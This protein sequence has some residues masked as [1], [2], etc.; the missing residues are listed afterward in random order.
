MG[1][2]LVLAALNRVVAPTSKLGFA[3]WWATTALDRFT[4]IPSR[5]LDHRRFWDA[6]HQV[7]ME[8]LG[9][10]EER[11]ALAMIEEFGLDISALALDRGCQMVCVRGG[12]LA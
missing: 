11:I 10:I 2:Y 4:K 3:D 7:T 6:M 1:T 8:Q 12:W 9:Q 5:V